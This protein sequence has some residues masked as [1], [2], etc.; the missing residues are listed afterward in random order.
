MW[1]TCLLMAH[2]CKT[3]FPSVIPELP[4]TVLSD[5]SLS[6]KGA[7]GKQTGGMSTGP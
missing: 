4:R 1:W 3:F 7:Y 6:G 5:A 2:N